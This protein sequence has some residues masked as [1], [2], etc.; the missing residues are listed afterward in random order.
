MSLCT[1]TLYT[2]HDRMCVSTR[3][4][5]YLYLYVYLHNIHLQEYVRM[6]DMQVDNVQCL[7]Y[8]VSCIVRIM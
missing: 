6:Y 1:V 3:V 5:V 7:M 4:Y 8:D 2:V